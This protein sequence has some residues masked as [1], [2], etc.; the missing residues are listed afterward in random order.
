MAQ[1]DGSD[2]ERELDGRRVTTINPNLTTGTDLSQA[3][4]LR[5]NLGIAFMGDTKGG[6][7]DIDGETARRLLAH[8]NPDGRSNAEVVRPW[9]NGLDITRRPRGM[10]IIDFG[11]GM[12]MSEA[13]LYEGPFEYVRTR[14]RPER[15]GSRSIISDWW[16]HERPRPEMRDSLRGLTRYIATPLTT[17]HRL[18]TWITDDVLLDHAA[19]AVARDDTFGV[20]HSRA[21][22]LWARGTGTQLR[23]VESGFRYTPTTTFETFPFPRPTDEQLDAIGEAARRLVALRDGWLNPPGLDPVEL[24]KRTLTNLYNE[25]PTWLQHAHAALDEAVI[26]T[27]GW[28]VDLPDEE[29][30]VRL[31]ALNLERE[32]A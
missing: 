21:H 12:P 32:P 10:W 22:E 7:F 15:M 19:V 5:E 17:K 1:D 4:R 26:A 18:F 14:V 30:L 20:L 27:Y 16:L 29:I 2:P 28:P 31:L 9:I 23:D 3:R 24:E 11:V 8:P 13:A 25:R 6:P